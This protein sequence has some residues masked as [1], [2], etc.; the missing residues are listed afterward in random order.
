MKKIVLLGD[1]IRMGYDK[2]V[3]EALAGSAEVFYPKENCKFALN[4]LRCI[5]E[6]KREGWGD[7]VDLVHWNAGLWDCVEVDS[8]KPLTPLAWY[9]ETVARVDK[10]LRA[11]FPKAKIIFATSTSVAEEKYT[12]DFCRHNAII[13]EYNAAAVRALASTDTVINDLYSL[14]K[15]FPDSYRSDATHFYT[16]KGTEMIGSRVLSLICDELDIAASAVNIDGF[17]P[18]NYSAKNIGN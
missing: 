7:D 16:D 17:V 3:K 4:I 15:S 13:E 12:P 2:Y 6:W 18:E 8:D 9:E 1:S 5:V 11:F 14:T 10:R